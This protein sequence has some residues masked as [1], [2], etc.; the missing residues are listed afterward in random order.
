MLE[1]LGDREAQDLAARFQ[2]SGK[3]VS[4][5]CHGVF[6]LARATDE[7][8]ES[9]L[10]GRQATTLPKWMEKLGAIGFRAVGR[11]RIYR[12]LW[13]EDVVRAAVGRDGRVRRGPLSLK[14][15]GRGDP[16]GFVVDTSKPGGPVITSQSPLTGSAL[17]GAIAD[18]LLR[19]PGRFRAR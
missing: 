4:A 9:L 5:I 13:A 14:P 17:G 7:S 19:Q 16:R 18:H 1:F 15:I 11:P 10:E 3:V 12:P 2:R 6:V 8:G